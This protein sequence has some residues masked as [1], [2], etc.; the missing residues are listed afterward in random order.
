MA[1]DLGLS[2]LA[3]IQALEASPRAVDFRRE[4]LGGETLADSGAATGWLRDKLH[5][6]ADRFIVSPYVADPVSWSCYATDMRA[7]NVTPA[8]D[9]SVWALGVAVRKL[10]LAFGREWLEQGPAYMLADVVPTLEPVR[11]AYEG[12]G[13]VEGLPRVSGPSSY[14]VVLTIRPQATIADVTSAY[15]ASLN[16]LPMAPRERAKPMSSPRMAELAVI[17]AR[18]YL[19]EFNSWQEARAV[20]NSENTMETAYVD[21]DKQGQF[22][23]DV[24]L[25]YKRVTGL[26]LDWKP[27]GGD[28][29][30]HI[31]TD[32]R[33]PF[34]FADH[35]R[36][37][38]FSATHRPG[39][40][41]VRVV[42]SDFK[43]T[44][45]AQKGGET[46]DD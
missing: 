19:L 41:P 22:R 18:A 37:G 43:K 16:R 15:Q 17:G 38:T 21:G 5:S 35:W 46:N 29:S 11:T 42:P 4:W 14:Q 10:A 1:D 36:D 7:N 44:L 45:Q 26:D 23:R 27:R 34:F 28:A 6:D 12:C 20:Y 8:E 32:L 40:D 33:H 30:A 24:R 25:A 9:S 13:D 39:E 3:K 2:A 31:S